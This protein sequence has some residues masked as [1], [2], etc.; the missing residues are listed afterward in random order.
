MIAVLL[1]CF[2]ADLTNGRAYVT[3]R[4]SV[5]N[6]CIVTTLCVLLKT[7]SE[8]ATRKYL[9]ANR[10]VTMK[11]QGHDPNM[12]KAHL[13][14]CWRWYLATI[15]NYEIVCCEAVRSAI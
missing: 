13:E 6:I 8:E 11:G 4:L 7:L 1:E 9:M 14:N 10:M 15:A 5:C 12:F 2:L 3:C